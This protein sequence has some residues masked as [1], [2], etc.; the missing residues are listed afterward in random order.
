MTSPFYRILVPFDFSR[1]AERALDAACEIAVASEA[2][3]TV[4]N[5]IPPATS[6]A[7]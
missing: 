3:L 6:L 2:E 4:L 1:P 7:G 5:A